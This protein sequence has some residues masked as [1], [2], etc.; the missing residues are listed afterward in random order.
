MSKLEEQFVPYQQSL[1]MKDLEFDEPCFAVYYNTKEFK[2]Y[3]GHWVKFNSEFDGKGIISAPLWQQAFD[4]FRE[5]H[6]LH[7]YI[8]ELKLTTGELVYD[9]V[10]VSDDI[11]EED[12]DGRKWKTVKEAQLACLVDLINIV[13]TKKL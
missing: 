4:W 3:T 9:Y 5:N 10:I 7:S 6:N 2:T 11:D 8:D 12:D 1:D 13:K